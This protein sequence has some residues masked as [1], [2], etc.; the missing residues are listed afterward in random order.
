[1]IPKVTRFIRLILIVYILF[2]LSFIAVNK[3]LNKDIERRKIPEF[4]NNPSR[5][6]DDLDCVETT[7]I[8]NHGFYYWPQW[9]FFSKDRGFDQAIYAPLD[10]TIAAVGIIGITVVIRKSNP[11]NT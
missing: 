3:G 5:A 6:L 8:K 9:Q 10:I 11:K 4:C 2:G 1:M 7:D